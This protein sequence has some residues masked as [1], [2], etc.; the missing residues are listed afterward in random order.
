[1]ERLCRDHDMNWMFFGASDFNGDI[2]SWNVS[3]V[4]DMNRMFSGASDFNGDI[5]NW[6]VSAVTGMNRMFSGASDFNGD[7]S[8]WNVS[9]VTDMNRMFLGLLLP[10]TSWNGDISSGW[11]TSLCRDRHEQDVLRRLLLQR[12]HL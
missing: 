6:N 8:N 2:S 11:A 7:I 12:R 10:A 3:A 9:A 4:T 1:M 5:S